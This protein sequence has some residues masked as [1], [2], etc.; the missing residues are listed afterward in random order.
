[1]RNI[2]V[3]FTFDIR[4]ELFMNNKFKFSDDVNKQVRSTCRTFLFFYC[5]SNYV[6]LGT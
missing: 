3:H 2:F 6:W 4:F 5:M 1:M